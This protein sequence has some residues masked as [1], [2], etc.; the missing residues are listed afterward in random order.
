MGP[1]PLDQRRASK[2]KQLSE[3]TSGAAPAAEG[4]SSSTAAASPPAQNQKATMP[5]NGK[6]RWLTFNAF[7]DNIAPRL[8]LAE[9]TVWLV[10]FRHARN[11]TCVISE[12]AIARHANIDKATAGKALRQ[13]VA[14]RLVWVVFKSTHKESLSRYGV[15]PSPAD[16]Q[17][18]VIKLHDHRTATA[19][20][21]RQRNGGDRRGRPR[22]EPTG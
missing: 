13:L 16:R 8:T 22:K 17:A 19:D 10:M 4:S 6:G 12:R 18:A 20:A 1:T 2:R 5:T 14:L 9:R 7:M 11:G 3:R 21:R 15:H